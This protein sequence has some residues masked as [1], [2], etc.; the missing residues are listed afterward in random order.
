MRYD[1]VIDEAGLKL[2]IRQIWK[3]NYLWIT[4]KICTVKLCVYVFVSAESNGQQQ[5]TIAITLSSLLVHLSRACV[6]ANLTSDDRSA[7]VKPGVACA[8]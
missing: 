7:P 8:R 3:K 5:V 1:C 2:A 6:I 4:Q